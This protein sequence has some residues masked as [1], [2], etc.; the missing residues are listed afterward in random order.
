M[1]PVQPVQTIHLFAPLDSK[2]IELLD[3]LSPEEWERKAL[4]HWT[5]KDI[6]AHLLDTA[7]RRLS[8]VRDGYVG[9]KFTGSSYQELLA[10]LNGLNADW[11]RALRRVSPQLLIAMIDESSHEL[12]AHFK[13]LDPSSPAPFPVAWSGEETSLNW[14]DIARE[15]TERWHH[16]QQIREAVNRPGI[17]TRELYYPLLDTFIRVLPHAYRNVGAPENT[18]ISVQI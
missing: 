13:T 5:V 18:T 1:T 2:L 17:M 16:Q 3:S 6:A 4:P 8:I 12:I 15:Y 14:F 10:F 7:L 9:E 11:V